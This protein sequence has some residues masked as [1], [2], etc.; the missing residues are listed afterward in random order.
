[1]GAAIFVGFMPAVKAQMQD[2]PPE[3]LINRVTDQSTQ[4]WR[5]VASDD[6]QVIAVFVAL[7]QLEGLPPLSVPVS[8]LIVID[9][10]NGTV[11][12]ASRTSEGGFQNISFPP[13]QG[14]TIDAGPLSISRDGRFV[15]FVSSATN[16]ILMHRPPVFTPTST[17]AT[18]NRFGR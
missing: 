17:T 3:R 7:G 1:M 16:L 9:R 12:L 2:Q 18:R 13:G 14:W 11:E 4:Y 10:R 5:M 8:Q 15:S 6:G